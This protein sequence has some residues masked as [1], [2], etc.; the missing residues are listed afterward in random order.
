MRLAAL[1]LDRPSDGH[2]PG[3]DQGGKG[4]AAAVAEGVHLRGQAAA[5]PAH[6]CEPPS[7]RPG[8]ASRCRRR[9]ICAAR[10][11]SEVQV[12]TSYETML[13]VGDLPAVVDAVTAIGRSA[14]VVPVADERV[15][16]IPREKSNGVAELPSLAAAIS[17]RLGRPVLTS[18]VFDSDLIECFV[19]QDG[20]PVHRYLSDQ[21]MM[22]EMFEDDDGKFK[23][24]IDGVV[25]PADH[26]I[27]TGPLGDDATRFLPFVVG[28]PD[29]D[30]LGAALRGDIDL[31]GQHPFMAE[32]QHRAIMEAL[33]LPAAPLTIAYRHLD[34][35]DFPTAIVV[36][37][38]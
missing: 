12:G 20:Q 5:G 28:A 19:Y 18:L 6:G 37:A 14:I 30:R 3:R 21:D 38:S 24:M 27:P 13:A 16:V 15:A 29:L 17:T 10:E 9:I 25:Y 31:E 1:D 2:L 34:L 4:A 23:P 26:Q 33:G 11:M 22:V 32:R 35:G 7:S 36:S 8:H